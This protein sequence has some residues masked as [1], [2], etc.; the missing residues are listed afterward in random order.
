MVT[1]YC[2]LTENVV[3]TRITIW[4]ESIYFESEWCLITAHT[5]A[6]GV[7]TPPGT[8]NFLFV[9]RVLNSEHVVYLI[10]SRAAVWGIA[11][12]IT[13]ASQGQCREDEQMRR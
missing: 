9:S 11:W 1:L 8:Q 2:I 7:Y 5:T 4:N 12:D 6:K 3:F 13:V 10:L